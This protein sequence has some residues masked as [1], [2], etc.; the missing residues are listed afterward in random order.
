MSYGTGVSTKKVF[1]N[2]LRD[3]AL[4][5]TD[6]VGL[7]REDEFGNKYRLIKNVDTTAFVQGQVI[8]W[9][10]AANKGTDAYYSDGTLAITAELMNAAG[11]CVTAIGESGA[12]TTSYG[13]VQVWGLFKD[14]IIRVPKTNDIEEGSELIAENVKTALAYNANAGSAPIYSNHFRALEVVATDGTG[15]ATTNIDIWIYCM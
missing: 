8:V 7:L 1:R 10:S 14:A 11:V 9:D 3:T 12:A 15:T 2:G 5:D 6:G 4:T 13:W